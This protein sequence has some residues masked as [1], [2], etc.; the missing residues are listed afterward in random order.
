[1]PLCYRC[2]TTNPLYN[3]KS[4]ACKN[5]LQPFFVSFTNFGKEKYLNDANVDQMIINCFSFFVQDILPLVEFALEDD[6][7]EEE[8]IEMIYSEKEKKKK[9]NE[10][11]GNYHHH[12]NDADVWREE[13]GNEYQVL[14]LQE[15]SYPSS[16]YHHHLSHHE[17]NDEEIFHDRVNLDAA[18][19]D[20]ND[21]DDPFMEKLSSSMFLL[22]ESD[23]DTCYEP[24]KVGKKM[25]KIL[26][27]ADVVIVS[28]PKPLTTKFYRN[29]MPDLTI[30]A[31][32][33]CS[34]VR[35]VN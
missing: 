30:L 11:S 7:N 25:L 33:H 28:W 3:S 31:C 14:K 2:S 12:P 1:M 16:S 34:R 35:L 21:D 5:C 26:K 6:V 27:P 4:N 15:S 8:A 18:G 22:Q 10:K 23:N 13:H 24:I 19:D 32:E 9:M 20:G 29:L 17:Q